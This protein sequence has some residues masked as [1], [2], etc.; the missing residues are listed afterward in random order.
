MG[1]LKVECDIGNVSDGFHTFNELYAHRCHLFVAL[2]Q[3][4]ATLSWR[5]GKHFDGT[6]PDGWFIAGM[7]LP[8]GDIS[9]HLPLDMWDL[10][11]GSDIATLDNSPEWDGHSAKD[12]VQRLS[13][14]KRG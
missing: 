11:D 13:D 3:S 5:A 12:V 10:L 6:M 14:W 4:N 8:S 7:H 9:Y 1:I 2:M